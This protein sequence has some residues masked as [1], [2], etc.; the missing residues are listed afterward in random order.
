MAES[1][2]TQNKV[3]CT[4]CQKPAVKKR[5]MCLNCGQ[6]AHYSCSGYGKSKVNKSCCANPHLEEET[7]DRKSVKD[8]SVTYNEDLNTSGEIYCSDDDDDGR[9]NTIDELKCKVTSLENENRRLREQLLEIV[10]KT[11]LSDKKIIENNLSKLKD[12]LAHTLNYVVTKIQE[13]EATMHVSELPRPTHSTVSCRP[14]DKITI[15]NG[16][17]L[18][19]TKPN[20]VASHTGNKTAN[21]VSKSTEDEKKKATKTENTSP[22]IKSSAP[23]DT[24]SVNEHWLTAA[25]VEILTLLDYKVAS[26]FCRK[27]GYGGAAILIRPNVRYSELNLASISKQTVAEVAGIFL[28]E[29]RA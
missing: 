24:T 17:K 18:T 13:F 16:D 23:D 29:Y 7:P 8:N 4:F 28:T 10:A 19:A 25:E 6:Y 12:E 9:I 11:R 21:P 22:T 1:H 27:K 26:S 15:K 2:D 20:P 5:V 3:L 14:K